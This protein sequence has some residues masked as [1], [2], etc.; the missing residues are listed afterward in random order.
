MNLADATLGANSATAALPASIAAQ[1]AYEQG[2]LDEA[3]WHVG[4]RSSI[5]RAHGHIECAIRQ[6]VV[7]ARIALAR[8]DTETALQIL[9]DALALADRRD[10]PR[11]A[12]VALFERSNILMSMQSLD[13]A[14]RCVRRLEHLANSRRAADQFVHN[15]IRRCATF[16]KARLGAIYA[17]DDGNIA[18]LR[19]LLFEAQ[20]EAHLLHIVHT[21][22]VLAEA[23]SRLGHTEEALEILCSAAKTGVT[24]G[25]FR[26]FLD[27]GDAIGDLL[28]VLQ[29]RVCEFSESSELVLFLASLLSHAAERR[30]RPAGSQRERRSSAMSEREREIV[31]LISLGLPNKRIAQNLSISPETVKTHVK[32]IFAKLSVTTR[33]EAVRRAQMLDLI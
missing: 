21:Q 26:S 29:V 7:T 27:A 16:A 17:P 12:A 25:L 33:T 9:D 20:A 22:I 24:V 30:Q 1:V 19:R 2:Q 8:A 31:E 23:L 13:E 4:N 32:N 6:S 11:L 3:E 28:V 10:W 18:V 15:E 5:V 14:Q